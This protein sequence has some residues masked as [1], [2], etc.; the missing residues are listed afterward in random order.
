MQ[1][2][3]P[4]KVFI[5]DDA[6]PIR[7]SLTEMLEHGGRVNVV[8]EAESP[9]E[10]I[11]GIRATHPQ[12]VILDLH[13]RGGS[14]IEVLRAIHSAAPEIR[15]LVITNHPAQQYRRICAAAGASH[16]LDKSLEFDRI[17]GLITADSQDGIQLQTH[18][19][20]ALPC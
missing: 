11:A 15:F 16:F 2:A 17:P 19:D 7:A 9:T 3:A 12:V 20:G 6:A 5:V 4:V 13:L 10:A 8:G 1:A 18:P 14:G